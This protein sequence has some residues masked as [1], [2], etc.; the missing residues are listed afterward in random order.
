MIIYKKHT[1]PAWLPK[2]LKMDWM[3]S[4]PYY[5]RDS[6]HVL[7]I[8]QPHTAQIFITEQGLKQFLE[9]QILR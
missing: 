2:H 5:G 8:D 9:I 4:M 1:P 3:I 6:E 7:K